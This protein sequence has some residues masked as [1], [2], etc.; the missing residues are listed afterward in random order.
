MKISYQW[1]S[2][3]VNLSSF[4]SEE[5]LAQELTRLGLEVEE[6][7][8]L[9]KGFEKV[10]TA[11]IIQKQKHPQADRLSL[12]Q[13]KWDGGG[14]PLQIVCGAQNMKEGDIVAL[15]QIGSCLPNGMK[16]KK[17]KIRGEES[18]GMLCSE[19]ELGLA[20]ESEGILVLPN[21][22]PTGR[23]LAQ[24]LGRE[25]TVF[26]ISLTPNRGD[27]LSHLGIAREVAA[28]TQ[29][30]VCLPKISDIPLK[31]SPIQ[32][33][34]LA[35]EEG[36]QFWGVAIEGVQIG[37]SPQWIRQKLEAVGLRSINNVV[38]ATNYVMLELGH[39][40][41]AYDM[42]RLEGKTLSIRKAQKGEKLH[43]L[44]DDEITFQGEE[45]VIADEKN[46]WH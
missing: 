22:T 24:V 5:K 21:E 43:L 7:T 4:S 28:I 32:T 41:H 8:S 12:C 40:L 30:K 46:Q 26:E 27:C 19:S 29:Q 34:L 15:A 39:P 33:Q 37:P 23:S 9:S 35:G 44:D 25:D 16:I 1:L 14:D 45:L 18:F 13:V 2:E 38:D 17:G 10:V 36:L 42:D 20:E 11:Q 3:L 31:G 6:V